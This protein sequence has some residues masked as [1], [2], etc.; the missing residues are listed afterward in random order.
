MRAGHGIV[1]TNELGTFV[2][3]QLEKIGDELALTGL[4][5]T[6]RNIV[7]HVCH[8]DDVPKHLFSAKLA[9][10]PEVACRNLPYPWI[11]NVVDMY[12]SPE[13]RTSP[14]R[15]KKGTKTKYFISRKAT[16]VL[17]TPVSLWMVSSKPGV[18]MSTTFHPSTT[19]SSDSWTSVVHNP[20]SFQHESW[21]HWPC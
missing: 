18:S 12:N 6:P 2:G 11:R 15:T 5:N 16:I 3:G 17:R 14:V 7:L 19:N 8:D 20:H 21:N 10:H 4:P 1:V 13:S 9:E